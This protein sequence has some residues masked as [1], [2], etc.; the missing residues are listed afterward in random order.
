MYRL[1]FRYAE[2]KKPW[3]NILITKEYKTKLNNTVFYTSCLY[4]VDRIRLF[5]I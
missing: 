3:W 5:I 4:I 1:Q 2:Y